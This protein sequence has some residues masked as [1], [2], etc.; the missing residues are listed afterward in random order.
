[1]SRRVAGVGMLLFALLGAARTSEAGLLEFIWGL[2]G[3]QMLGTGYGCTLTFKGNIEDCR[4]GASLT[5]PPALGQAVA[6]GP[7]LFLGGA[8]LLSTGRDS[9]QSYDGLEVQ[10]VELTP[11]LTF[12]SWTSPSSNFRVSHGAGVA[13]DFFSGDRFQHFTKVAFASTLVGFE[14]KRL[15][16]SLTFR[17]YPDGVSK[18]EFRNSPGQVV[19]HNGNLERVYGATVNWIYRK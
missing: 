4:L 5:P 1:M 19:N 14:Y 13:F 18:E 10:M 17:I 16:L 15:V 7:F 6:R 3:P 9:D 12:R 2:S 11:A 8:L